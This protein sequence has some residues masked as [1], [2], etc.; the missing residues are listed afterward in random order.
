MAEAGKSLP[1]LY[2]VVAIRTNGVRVTLATHLSKD[3]AEAIVEAL[4]DVSAFLTLHIE[5]QPDSGEQPHED[6]DPQA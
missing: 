6:E 1:D 5:P 2:C 3:R 4:S